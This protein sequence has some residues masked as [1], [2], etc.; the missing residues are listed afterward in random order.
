M[1]QIQS[2]NDN[3]QSN[4]TGLLDRKRGLMMN[5]GEISKSPVYAKILGNALDAVRAR[6]SF[7][8]VGWG[9]PEIID[10]DLSAVGYNGLDL[11]EYNSKVE[12]K[13]EPCVFTYTEKT[14]NENP[15]VLDF[16][17]RAEKMPRESCKET[18]P[19][20]FPDLSAWKGKRERGSWTIMKAN[21]LPPESK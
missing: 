19:E 12:I 18:D 2:T 17:V 10:F 14:N 16:E 11:D 21:P 6:I 1:I 4:H 3:Q 13:M 20:M 7:N 5:F 8:S 9:E 15:D